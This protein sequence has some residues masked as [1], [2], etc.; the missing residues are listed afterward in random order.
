MKKRFIIIGLWVVL[1]LSMV[2]VIDR[3]Y[4]EEN[5]EAALDVEFVEASPSIPVEAGVFRRSEMANVSIGAEVE[6]KTTLNDYHQGRAYPGAPPVIPHEQFVVEGIGGNSC[7]Q[8]HENGGY[9][10]A[11]KAYTPITPHPEMISCRQC[12]VPVTTQSLFA[13]SAWERMD[14]AA[15][16]NTALPGSPPVI[17]HELQMRENCLSCHSGPSAPKEIRVSHPER[18]NCR[19]CHAVNSK[20]TKSDLE[21]TR[22]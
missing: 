19:Q 4:T 10:E 5:Q 14:A 7:L 2:A 22:N 20:L 13:S 9:V 12:H 17:P 21:W 1:I 3:S 16:G 18:V 8:C 6:S 15:V 11:L